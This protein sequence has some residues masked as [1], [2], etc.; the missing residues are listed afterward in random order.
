MSRCTQCGATVK[1]RS[2]SCEYCGAR[3][4]VSA[5]ESV[6]GLAE[7]RFKQRDAAAAAAR[8]AKAESERIEAKNKPKIM[9]GLAIFLVVDMLFLV[10]MSWNER[11]WATATTIFVSV[12]A[13]LAAS[14][15]VALVVWLARRRKTPPA[16]I[17]QAPAPPVPIYQTPAPPDGWH[18][19]PT[20]RHQ[21]GYWSDNTWTATVCDGDVV[22]EDPI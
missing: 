2:K 18:P 17:Y 5:F 14:A 10:S 16:S 12:C 8:E 21:Y 20:S 9:I 3:V 4:E 15:V 22:S 1:A 13:L 7:D 11:Q 19:D 6:M